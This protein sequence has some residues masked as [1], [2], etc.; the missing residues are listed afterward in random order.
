MLKQLS[1]TLFH[2]NNIVITFLQTEQYTTQH[3]TVFTNLFSGEEYV[4]ALLALR[5]KTDSPFSCSPSLKWQLQ[6][7]EFELGMAPSPRLCH[8][9][10][11][12]RESLLA[13]NV[14]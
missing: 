10:V 4:K 11:N 5:S 7:R 1:V 13:M 8:P 6:S 9:H 2:S 12:V 3:I 14:F